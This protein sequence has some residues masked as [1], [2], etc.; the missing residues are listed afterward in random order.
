MRKNMSLC[1]V[2]TFYS[3]CNFISAP[4]QQSL[5]FTKHKIG[6]TLKRKHLICDELMFYVPMAYRGR[7][8]PSHAQ[9]C[10]W[11][12]GLNGL[13]MKY[14]TNQPFC[15]LIN[16]W[17]HVFNGLHLKKTHAHSSIHKK[18]ILQQQNTTIKITHMPQNQIKLL[19]LI[20]RHWYQKIS[21]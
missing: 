8:C 16:Y 2:C 1:V 15:S 18:M 11:N 7:L 14:Q 6:R 12:N 17:D 4:A 9:K 13:S 10:L 5:A 21:K 20:T 19:K 3:I